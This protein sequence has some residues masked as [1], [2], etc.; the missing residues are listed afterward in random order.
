[1]HNIII[2]IYMCVCACVCVLL[3]LFIIIVTCNIVVIII[4]CFP[5]LIPPFW[6]CHA[7]RFL[8][9]KVHTPI[10]SYIGPSD[11]FNIKDHWPIWQGKVTNLELFSPY[12]RTLPQLFDSLPRA[13]AAKLLLDLSSGRP[14]STVR[15]YQLFGTLRGNQSWKLGEGIT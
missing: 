3:L 13:P 9:C 7:C 5:A 2:Y 14:K 1:M 12:G 6:T 15:D 10:H 11:R 4:I 8:I